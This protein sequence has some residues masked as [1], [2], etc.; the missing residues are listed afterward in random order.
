[1][2][3]HCFFSPVQPGRGTPVHDENG[4][5]KVDTTFVGMPVEQWG[6]SNKT[7]PALR[8]PRFGGDAFKVAS[9]AGEI[10]PGIKVAK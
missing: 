9:D 10:V 2:T 8:A 5:R 1:M 7:S 4:N 6:V 3:P